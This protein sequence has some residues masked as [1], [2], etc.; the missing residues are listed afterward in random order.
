MKKSHITY[1]ELEQ[2]LKKSNFLQT[3]PKVHAAFNQI[4]NKNPEHKITKVN[5]M[6][7][8]FSDV[9]DNTKKD[10]ETKKDEDKI[11]Y[12][13][14]FHNLDYAIKVDN[15]NVNIRYYMKLLKVKSIKNNIFKMTQSYLDEHYDKIDDEKDDEKDDG[16]KIEKYKLKKEE[17]YT[18][19]D[20][21]ELA[22]EM[23]KT[24][25][26]V[27]VA[28]ASTSVRKVPVDATGSKSVHTSD[29]T[30]SKSLHESTS[31]TGSKIVHP[32]S[33]AKAKTVSVNITIKDFIENIE[34]SLVNTPDNKKKY[35]IDGIIS[36]INKDYHDEID[37]DSTKILIDDKKEKYN[38]V[39][40]KYSDVAK[41]EYMYETTV[42]AGERLLISLYKNIYCR[43]DKIEIIN[44]TMETYINI[45]NSILEIMDNLL[46]Y[47]KDTDIE[48][49]LAHFNKIESELGKNEKNKNLNEM[50]FNKIPKKYDIFDGIE[51]Y[52]D[53]NPRDKS[54]YN[55]IDKNI[56][57]IDNKLYQ[58]TIYIFTKLFNNIDTNI[59]F[60]DNIETDD[61]EKIKLETNSK[62][63]LLQIEKMERQK[64]Y[65]DNIINKRVQQSRLKIF[66]DIKKICEN[67]KPE[68]SDTNTSFYYNCLTAL[69]WN[70]RN[71]TETNEKLAVVTEETVKTSENNFKLWQVW[72]WLNCV[73]SAVE[74]VEEGTGKG[75]GEGAKPG[76]GE[77]AKPGTGE[78]TGEVAGEV[79]GKGTGKGAEEGTGKGVKKDDKEGTGKGTG[80]GAEEGAGEGAKPGAKPGDALTFKLNTETQKF[81]NNFW[82][83]FKKKEK[84]GENMKGAQ[85]YVDNVVD[86]AIKMNK[87]QLSEELEKKIIDTKDKLVKENNKKNKP[88]IE[89]INNIPTYLSSCPSYLIPSMKLFF[90]T[91]VRIIGFGLLVVPTGLGIL[92][93]FNRFIS[94][95]NIKKTNTDEQYEEIINI[96]NDIKKKEKDNKNELPVI[97]IDNLKHRFNP[98]FIWIRDIFGLDVINMGPLVGV[99]NYIA[100]KIP[101]STELTP[102]F[103]HYIK[104]HT[105]QNVNSSINMGKLFSLTKKYENTNIKNF[106]EYVKSFQDF[107]KEFNE[108]SYTP[109]NT[110]DNLGGVADDITTVA[111]NGNPTVDTRGAATNATP[112]VPTGVPTGVTPVVTPG[113]TTVDTTVKPGGVSPVVPRNIYQHLFDKIKGMVNTY[114]SN[115]PIESY[116]NY[117]GIYINQ[118]K[119]NV[120]GQLDALNLIKSFYDNYD[121]TLDGTIRNSDNKQTLIDLMTE[122]TARE[123]AYDK[124]LPIINMNYVVEQLSRI[125]KAHNDRNKTEVDLTLDFNNFLRQKYINNTADATNCTYKEIHYVSFDKY[126]ELLKDLCQEINI[127]L[128]DRVIN[129]IKRYKD[130]EDILSD[131]NIDDDDNPDNYGRYIENNDD[132]IELKKNLEENYLNRV[133]LNN[134]DQDNDFK[135]GNIAVKVVGDDYTKFQ[136]IGENALNDNSGDTK[137]EIGSGDNN[138]VDSSVAD[139][140]DEDQTYQ[141]LFNKIQPLVEAYNQKL[142][143]EYNKIPIEEILK[144]D[145]NDLFFKFLDKDTDVYMKEN[146]D[147]FNGKLKM[148]TDMI[149]G[150]NKNLPIISLNYAID[151]IKRV[152][153]AHNNDNKIKIIIDKFIGDRFILFDE[154]KNTY[155]FVNID[156]VSF[157]DYNNLLKSACQ[158]INN[159]LYQQARQYVETFDS[160]NKIILT[161]YGLNNT[162]IPFDED[163]KYVENNEK[164]K[165]LVDDI[166]SSY[167]EN[168]SNKMGVLKVKVTG[169]KYTEFEIDE[170]TQSEDDDKNDN[171]VKDN[172]GTTDEDHD[173]I[174]DDNDTSAVNKT[175]QDFIDE[176]KPF[177]EKY[178]VEHP[179]DKYT[180]FPG[181]EI[182]N[183]SAL[184]TEKLIKFF[185]LIEIIELNKNV[186]DYK[187]RI[188][189]IKIKIENPLFLPIISLEYAIDQIKKVLNAHNQKN[190]QTNIDVNTFINRNI[191]SEKNDRYTYKN[192]DM[193]SFE[194]YNNI[195]KDACKNINEA[196][197]N[198]LRNFI[199]KKIDDKTLQNEKLNEFGLNPVYDSTDNDYMFV[200]NNDKYTNLVNTIK[201][202]YEETD[203]NK[204]G[205]ITVKV[206]NNEYTNF[207]IIQESIEEEESSTSRPNGILPVQDE[208]IKT[209]EEEAEGETL[210]LKENVVITKP[211]NDFYYGDIEKQIIEKLTVISKLKENIKYNL[212]ENNQDIIDFVASKLEVSTTTILNHD[213][214]NEKIELINQY[215]YEY[216][217]ELDNELDAQETK[218][219]LEETK[220]SVEKPISSEE[221][222]NDDDNNETFNLDELIKEINTEWDKQFNDLTKTEKENFKEGREEMI[223]YVIEKLE[224][225]VKE[226]F[227]TKVIKI[228]PIIKAYIE[229]YIKEEYPYDFE[230][231]N[232]DDLDE[233]GQP[234]EV[235]KQSLIPPGITPTPNKTTLADYIDNE[236]DVYNKTTM[237]NVKLE[238]EM[239]YSYINID[240][241]KAKTIEKDT[242]DY[243]ELMSVV[244]QYINIIISLKQDIY[245][246]FFTAKNDY[247]ALVLT[248]K[249]NEIEHPDV[250]TYFENMEL[251]TD[252]KYKT[253]GKKDSK[254]DLC[255]EDAKKYLNEIYEVKNNNNNQIESQVAQSN[256]GLSLKPLLK[257]LYSYN[258][259]YKYINKILDE[260]VIYEPKWRQSKKNLDDLL[261]ERSVKSKMVCITHYRGDNCKN[262]TKERKNFLKYTYDTVNN[263][264]LAIKK[265]LD[266]QPPNVDD[267]T[268]SVDDQTTS[269][270]DQTTSITPSP[271]TVVPDGAS[272]ENNIT[273]E[274]IE[275]KIKKIE[276]EYSKKLDSDYS[277]DDSFYYQYNGDTKIYYP[278]TPNIKE[279]FTAPQKKLILEKV[280]D[281]LEKRLDIKQ[282]QIQQQQKKDQEEAAEQKKREDNEKAI[283]KIKNDNKKKINDLI[284][285]KQTF[286]SENIVSKSQMDYLTN[287][288]NITKDLLIKNFENDETTLT[289]D[290]INKNFEEN[291]KTK[292]NSIIKDFYE[293]VEKLR[294]QVYLIYSG[295][296]VNEIFKDFIQNYY[297]QQHIGDNLIT[298]IFEDTYK[299]FEKGIGIINLLTNKEKHLN[300]LISRINTFIS[301]QKDI[302]N[303]LNYYNF[304]D[305]NQREIRMKA[306]INLAD[307]LSTIKN[308]DTDIYTATGEFQ[309]AIN[310]DTNSLKKSIKD[311]HEESFERIK[312]EKIEEYKETNIP[313]VNNIPDID[314]KIK[315]YFTDNA[316]KYNE[317]KKDA[318][319]NELEIIDTQSPKVMRDDDFRQRLDGFLKTMKEYINTL[320]AKRLNEIEQNKKQRI[321]R[322][323]DINNIN[324]ATDLTLIQDTTE[325]PLTEND[326]LKN[327]FINILSQKYG[328][329]IELITK[330]VNNAYYCTT[331]ATALE[332]QKTCPSITEIFANEDDIINSYYQ[333]YCKSLFE[334]ITSFLTINKPSD[335]SIKGKQTDD[336]KLYTKTKGKINEI[337]RDLKTTFKDHAKIKQ[338]LI[339]IENWLETDTPKNR[340]ELHRECTTNNTI[341]KKITNN[342]IKWL[343]NLLITFVKTNE[344]NESDSKTM[345]YIQNQGTDEYIKEIIYANGISSI[346]F[347][348]DDETVKK[349]LEAIRNHPSFQTENHFLLKKAPV[350]TRPRFY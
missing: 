210:I 14:S 337:I 213:E 83:C 284:K 276:D 179:T 152:L 308:A 271:I 301:K 35:I 19:N 197:Y 117:F 62:F 136:I 97:T 41:K 224:L 329:D 304:Y 336:Y 331:T 60:K 345:K 108:L 203:T 322:G 262:N 128:N 140:S 115:N 98:E 79:A 57:Y 306:Y 176:I 162:E 34:S 189:N 268:T 92:L 5:Y 22:D 11:V 245:N 225:N 1:K 261:K 135:L 250:K 287:E 119:D 74:D 204:M 127:I 291:F 173:K 124:N 24:D 107:K 180:M 132:Y 96:Y 289:D 263:V 241:E 78:G 146:V 184:D 295:H 232:P 222:K 157:D 21:F 142:K 205:V 181:I 234:V 174:V 191:I 200:E 71:A 177:V 248:Q 244:N 201:S 81:K 2:K 125:V 150:D 109:V 350:I 215:I 185:T 198:Q 240:E 199:V 307:K 15:V 171:A 270:D 218:S 348:L 305:K 326:K 282:E 233:K 242:D 93:L 279:T 187:R 214:Y 302:L 7:G 166:T 13:L 158:E 82:S 229:A 273:Y 90:Y 27:L 80:E 31:A 190:P 54:D 112:V 63:Q 290:T 334:N 211:S 303:I 161:K 106:I 327:S 145:I 342:V 247:N 330:F 32:P 311:Y 36:I 280:E 138:I 275:N 73:S 76:T 46:I 343:V 59:R 338:K 340:N 272:T 103:N 130:Y 149:N 137:S 346:S 118:S 321:D 20:M 188:E 85:K 48:K 349:L 45:V 186:E 260:D 281:I 94:K 206:D 33:S 47:D 12:L 252:T 101:K 144:L 95:I 300:D 266:N 313:V 75:T 243:N 156:K 110:T 133:L 159:A 165:K 202:R 87:D 286:I 155:L 320:N 154:N 236:I 316:T 26:E 126:N 39:L 339:D 223:K 298:K 318:I 168:D 277:I 6:D 91:L 40:S 328:N 231:E 293:K 257:D 86:E 256:T 10:D 237:N 38:E 153:N 69:K 317:M 52:N 170:E 100:K 193:I 254:Y 3:N 4:D 288:I 8:K 217:S 99:K 114:N 163:H 255:I 169:E 49:K 9:I 323:K 44:T 309:K 116:E 89:F 274:H 297:R 212:L 265:F 30:G 235:S 88:I 175:W 196:L 64:K 25:T 53:L 51:D 37:R 285:K 65:F 192:T 324:E 332:S 167:R 123:K 70:K 209:T 42:S 220:S 312:N 310:E 195:L 16:T 120:I 283:E 134:N 122:I 67:K 227:E 267:Q 111:N 216:I 23:D 315:K 172:N 29:A 258:T 319:G 141:N 55:N 246:L 296:D 221:T 183:I 43:E 239:I 66:E 148:L 121:M 219:G 194:I 84:N 72:Q 28:S 68:S 143:P 151:Q 294:N 17:D 249:A 61:D 344:S 253:M 333:V 325:K 58:N 208:Q 56:K 164:Y 228:P 147:D 314:K 18:F 292:A 238:K 341:I 131:N 226:S 129:Y 160:G 259:L 113:D 207:K 105:K 102:I 139:E 335:T 77:G 182:E 251:N 104:E 278:K 269:V 264:L 178:N 50:L 230:Q 299:D 347:K